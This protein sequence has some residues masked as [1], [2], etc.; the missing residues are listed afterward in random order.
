MTCVEIVSRYVNKT[1]INGWYLNTLSVRI[2][3]YGDKFNAHYQT[4]TIERCLRKLIEHKKI[5]LDFEY[6]KN[7]GKVWGTF[8]PYKKRIEQTSLF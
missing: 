3:K 8:D 4:A 2:Q 6:G 1:Q 5:R 7:N